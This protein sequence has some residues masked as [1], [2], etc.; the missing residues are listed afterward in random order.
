VTDPVSD[1]GLSDASAEAVVD[2][3]LGAGE[4]AITAIKAIGV[5]V[6]RLIALTVSSQR[7]RHARGVTGQ[8]LIGSTDRA[9]PPV[10]GE[11]LAVKGEVADPVPIGH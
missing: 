2:L 3:T 4:R 7:G 1:G 8:H 10:K 9:V 11:G 6:E 5:T